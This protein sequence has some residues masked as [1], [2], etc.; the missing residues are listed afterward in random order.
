[1]DMDSSFP[2]RD[3][4]QEQRRALAENTVS[5]AIHMRGLGPDSANKSI[6]DLESLQLTR[7]LISSIV[8]DLTKD[9]IWHKDAFSLRIETGQG[10]YPTIQPYL[11]GETRFGDSLDDEWMVV[12]LLREITKRIP[13]SIARVQD[14]DGEFLL[15]EAAD[16]IP[17]WLDP[18]NSDN[19][20]FIFEGNLHIVPI[21]VTADEKKRLPSTVG[22]RSKP[23]KLQDAMDMVLSSP[24]MT[25]KADVDLACTGI[26]T[27][28]ST[29][30][31]QAAF[32]PIL[33]DSS[34]QHF[35]VRKIQEQR[36]YAQ[37]LIPLDIARILKECPELVTRASE[38]F[39]TRDT[40]AMAACSRMLMGQQFQ[41]PKIWDGIVPPADSKEASDPERVKEAELGMKLTCGFEILCSPDYP[42]DFGFKSEM[43]ISI[44][45]YPF[46][47]DESWR[48]FKENLTTREY[49]QDE[50]PGS[51]LYQELEKAAKK[52]FLEY[53]S[54]QFLEGE[55]AGV[56]GSASLHGHSYHPVQEIER[57]L[58]KDMESR[59]L[60]ALV[61]NRKPDDDSWMNVD[62]QVLEDMMRARGFG[63]GA[64]K[65]TDHPS[66]A[67]LDMQQML[68][69]FGEFIQEGEG[70]I[71]GAEFLDEQS[72]DEDD[73]EE[74][75]DNEDQNG[76]DSNPVSIDAAGNL[77]GQEEDDDDDDV[78]ASDYE[79][80]QAR[81]QAAKRGK[82]GTSGA[83]LF[84][85]DTMAFDNGTLSESAVMP[86]Q[87]KT[88]L[89]GFAVDRGHFKDILTRT[90]GVPSVQRDKPDTDR[91]SDVNSAELTDDDRELQDYMEILDAE[92]AGTKVGQSFEKML[93]TT[94]ASSASAPS[95]SKPTVD[96]GKGRAS[97]P[98]AQATSKTQEEN[99]EDLM[100]E[101]TDRSRR[102]FSRHGPLPVSG[103]SYGYDP[104]AAVFA[105]D[106]DDDEDQDRETNDSVA[107]IM[108]LSDDFDRDVRGEDEDEQE[109]V[110]V[111]LNLA[112]N[113]L[114]SFKSQGGLPGPGGNMLSRLGIMLPRDEGADEDEEEGKK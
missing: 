4:I 23:P 5:Y 59:E 27:L 63:G 107:H 89:Q 93:T 6:N 54:H 16:Y 71:E 91:D 101:Y 86:S 28:A 47:T 105:D 56:L 41:S 92:L 31:Q 15:I 33:P 34:T 39:Y 113:L 64:S 2:E 21:A 18:D 90:F 70:G 57:I 77:E 78:F 22:T 29:K 36:H 48:I 106:E 40:L 49:F 62:L 114:E 82:C 38:A 42:G 58:S 61:D 96:K 72:A 83:F 20:V 8:A 25:A 43:D 12:F 109:V 103:T 19:R 95:V 84:G 35:A 111:D 7:T 87:S 68:D 102:G 88:G 104:A 100:K 46:A 69:R 98:R 81:K 30:I 67:G 1:M 108:E 26:T 32:G 24:C 37:C 110:D 13:G 85:S 99:L 10:I 55:G 112:K 76:G 80:R 52:Q 65:E 75:T 3:Q 11:R 44:E 17:S 73:E 60:E 53:K 9:Y 79:E 14:N 51:M 74:E 66:K 50:R 45:E 97:A 94:T